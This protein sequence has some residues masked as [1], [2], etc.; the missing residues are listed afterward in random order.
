VKLLLERNAV[1]D[2]LDISG[3]TP[4]SLAAENGHDLVVKLLLE[5]NAVV[6]S[7][8]KSGRTPLAWAAENGHDVV[9]KLCKI[10]ADILTPTQPQSSTSP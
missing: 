6:D 10:T 2:S 1:V 7:L 3:R 5:R 4:L 9:V 8:D